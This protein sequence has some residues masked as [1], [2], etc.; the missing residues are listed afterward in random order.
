MSSHNNVDDNAFLFFEGD[1]IIL[2]II[3]LNKIQ[4]FI[5]ALSNLQ[6]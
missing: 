1:K 2:N 3:I 6:I 4:T 5:L